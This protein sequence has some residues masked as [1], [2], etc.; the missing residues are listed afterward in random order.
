[1]FLCVTCVISTDKR[2]EKTWKIPRYHI[3]LSQIYIKYTLKVILQKF[4]KAKGPHLVLMSGRGCVLAGIKGGASVHICQCEPI[5]V[6]F[7]FV[8][9]HWCTRPSSS[10]AD[11]PRIVLSESPEIRI[12]FCRSCVQLFNEKTMFLFPIFLKVII[13]I[14]RFSFPWSKHRP[15]NW[16][17]SRC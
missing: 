4:A 5:Y 6:L 16:N 3:A 17:H 9:P 15:L 8:F 2:P 14:N 13:I 10:Q 1:M 11:F 7:T 12:E